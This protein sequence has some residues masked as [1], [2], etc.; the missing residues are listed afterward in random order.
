MAKIVKSA[1]FDKDSTFPINA[2]KPTTGKK[3]RISTV[4]G[5]IINETSGKVVLEI[6][7]KLNG[8][9][10]KVQSPGIGSNQS[11]NLVIPIPNDF[12]TDVGNGTDYVIRIQKHSNTTSTNWSGF[13]SAIGE[14][15]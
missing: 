5:H 15:L 3:V 11:L 7:M 1:H 8:S 9:W 12:Y 13:L 2:W 10:K 6:E 4:S 14:E